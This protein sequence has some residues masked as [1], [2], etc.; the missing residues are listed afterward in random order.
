MNASVAVIEWLS[1]LMQNKSPSHFKYEGL[2]HNHYLNQYSFLKILIKVLLSLPYKK[3]ILYSF[4]N[5]LGF[6]FIC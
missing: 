6:F 5:H 2:F 1:V 4:Q 3:R